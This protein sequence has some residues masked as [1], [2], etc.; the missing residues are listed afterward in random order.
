MTYVAAFHCERGIVMCADTQESI[1]EG[2]NY[3]E[4]L[5]AIGGFSYPLAI[6]SAGGEDIIRPMVDEIGGTGTRKET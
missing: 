5:E 1:G 6:G 3:V 4:K 2:K